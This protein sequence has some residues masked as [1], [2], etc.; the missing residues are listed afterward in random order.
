MTYKTLNE[1]QDYLDNL[2]IDSQRTKKCEYINLIVSF[3]IETTSFK[4]NG[5]KQAIMY[6]WQVAIKDQVF[7][8]RTWSE[9]IEFIDIIHRHFET[10]TNRRLII[11]VHN[12]SFEFQWLWTKF[13]WDKVFAIKKRKVIYAITTSGIEFRCTYLMSGYSLDSLAKNLIHHKIRKLKG[14][15]DYEIIHTPLTPLTDKELSYCFNDVL[16]VNAYIEEQL[17]EFGDFH[18]LPLTNTGRV[19]KYCKE[20]CY[21]NHKDPK[22]FKEYTKLMKALTLAVDEYDSLKRAYAGGFT[23]ASNFHSTE[24]LRNCDS[25]DFTSSYPAVMLSELY[26]MSKGKKVFPKDKKDFIRYNKNYC[27]VFDIE[28]YN[29]KEKFVYE[30]YI[31]ESKCFEK[32]NV[33]T[34]NGR[35]V[36]ADKI[37]LTITNVDFE[38]IY[39][40]YKFDNFKISNMWIYKKGYLPKPLIECILHFYKGKTSL[41]GIEEEVINYMRNKGYINSIYG[42]MVTEIIRGLIECEG[43]WTE[44]SADKREQLIK[45]NNSKNR[46]TFYPWGVFVCAFARRNLWSGIFEFKEDY[47]YSDTD[48]IKC[49]NVQKH[50]GYI[51]KYNQVITNKMHKCADYYNISYEEFAPKTIKGVA[52]PIGVW[53][54]ETEDDKYLRF[55][56]VGAKRYLYETNDGLHMTVSGVDKHKGAEYLAYGWSYSLDGKTE[57]NNPFDKFDD[58]LYFPPEYS[59]KLT[60]TYIDTPIEGIIADYQGVCYNYKEDTCVHLEKADYTMSLYDYY[61]QYLKGVQIGCH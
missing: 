18:H 37:A 40:N 8:G 45:Y 43:E 56:T 39:H 50:L 61:L 41:K 26:P 48:S 53:D 25:F 2:E 17:E 28:L 27:T 3:D 5:M 33:K 47:I 11:W 14:D 60:H 58:G 29:V 15:L 24:L 22:Q 13:K 20:A 46:F 34:D 23:H 55:K 36:S 42:M 1:L 10:D 6:V 59:G 12:L 35:I 7:I 21:G 32:E 38:V 57:Y 19:R 52:K 9:F 51:E 54:W 4:I 30:H 16:I 31:S 44:E 49:K